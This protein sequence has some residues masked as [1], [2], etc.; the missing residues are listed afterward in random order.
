MKGTGN[1]FEPDTSMTRAMLATVLWRLA[2]SP[3][4]NYALTFDDVTEDAWYA[5][6]VR[7]AASEKITSGTSDTTFGSDDEITREQLAA[8]LYR[9]IQ[10]NR[11]DTGKSAELDIYA[12]SDSISEYALSALKWAVGFGIIK[13]NTDNVLCPL[14]FA[15]RAEAA[16]MLVRFCEEASK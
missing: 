10:R 2:G 9:Y 1:N 3:V 14:D 12:D 5:E 16:T 13:G 8:M 6:A 15:T 7:W 11:L 4:V